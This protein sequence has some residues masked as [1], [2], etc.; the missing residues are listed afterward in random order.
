MRVPCWGAS[1]L[2]GVQP[3]K[4]KEINHTLDSDGLLQ[5]FIVVVGDNERR[6]GVDR[7]PDANAVSSYETTVVGLAESEGASRS[8]IRRWCCRSRLRR[9]G[10]GSNDVSMHC[11]TFLRCQTRGVATYRSGAACLPA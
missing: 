11:W 2:G 8:K 1:V 9:C 6:A 5:R 7:A 4:M 10:N 3:K